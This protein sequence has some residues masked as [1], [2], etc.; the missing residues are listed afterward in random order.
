MTTETPSTTHSRDNSFWQRSLARLAS[1]ASAGSLVL[2][3]P[4]GA[5][6]H[7][8]GNRAG[9]NAALTI[10]S[11][12]LFWR[13]W[14]RGDL[15][16]A[17]AYMMGECDTPDLREL[18]AWALANEADLSAVMD[19]GIMSF[20]ASGMHRLRPNTRF[21]AR[22][23]IRHHYD[24]SNAFYETWL[25]PSM[26]YSAGWFGGDLSQSLE[27]SQHAKYARIVEMAG[28]T[29]GH[30]VLEIGCG[31]GGFCH[32]AAQEIGCRITAV[33]ISEAQH[34]YAQARLEQAALRHLVDIKLMDYRDLGGSFDA[35]VSIEMV[36]AVGEK[37]WPV[38]GDVLRKR[39][40]P[41]GRALLQA[42]T[43][44]EV[45]FHN[46]SNRADFIQAYIFPG[47]M[48]PTPS[49]LHSMA[50]QAGL[51]PVEREMFGPDYAETLRRW[52]RSF[53]AAWPPIEKLG[54]DERFRRM[55][56]YYLAYCETGFDTGRIDVGLFAMDQA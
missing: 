40:R 7:S 51:K 17:E 11:W 38:Y 54:V 42:I 45:S 10:H 44:D 12:R 56:R 9:P 23:N 2:A 37:F 28:I 16:F 20:V 8:S 34:E 3:F 46:Y 55:W 13:M 26:T 49:A 6:V 47:G 29:R 31:W 32:W 41:G 4:N 27:A 21:G 14:S 35:I 48:L 1:K 53:E 30:H 43:I 36:E 22:R 5:V 19:G 25:D 52:R 15:G 39:L 24:L 33:T 18:M 50:L